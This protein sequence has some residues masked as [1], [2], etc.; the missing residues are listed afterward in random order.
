M[1]IPMT[2]GLYVSHRLGL[3]VEGGRGVRFCISSSLDR[4]RTVFKLDIR[5]PHGLLGHSSSASDIEVLGWGPNT[6]HFLFFF[7]NNHFMEND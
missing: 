6:L 1:C 7:L 2:W 4:L 3:G 5:T